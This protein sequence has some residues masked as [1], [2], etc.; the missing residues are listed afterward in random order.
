M[1]VMRSAFKR[2]TTRYASTK[3]LQDETYDLKGLNTVSPD[4][5]MPAGESPYT[6]NARMYAKNDGESRVAIL[7]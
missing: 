2:Q 5:V 7:S 6:I 4:Q 1:V 3:L